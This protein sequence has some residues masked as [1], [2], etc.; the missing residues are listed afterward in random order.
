MFKKS[1][2]MT[3]EMKLLKNFLDHFLIYIKNNLETSMRGS[4][5]ICDCVHLL[6]YKCHKIDPNHCESYI[7]FTVKSKSKKTNHI[8]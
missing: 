2:L 3:K 4:G 8:N 5:F 6:Y 1:R 7:D